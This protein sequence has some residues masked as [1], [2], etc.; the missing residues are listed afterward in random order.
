MKRLWETIV[1]WCKSKNYTTG[2]IVALA[3]G[4]A[5]FYAEN[6]DFRAYVTSLFIN[7]PQVLAAISFAVTAYL[8]ASHSSSDAGKVAVAEVIMKS[9]DRPTPAAIDAANTAT[10]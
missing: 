8:K 9:P 6:Q 1:A 5:G 4:V 7:H 3:G 2:T 10:K